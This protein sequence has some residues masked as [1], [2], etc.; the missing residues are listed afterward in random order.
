[1]NGSLRPSSTTANRCYSRL[2]R[3]GLPSFVIL[4][5]G[6]FGWVLSGVDVAL[7][8]QSGAIGNNGPAASTTEV[9]DRPTLKSGS[10]GTEVSE[11][12]ATLKLL[13]YYDGTVDG[14][15]GESTVMAVSSFQQAAGLSSDGIVGPATW[16]RLFPPT[17]A[18]SAMSMAPTTG[19]PS[20]S[21]PVSGT[22][23]RPGNPAMAVKPVAPETVRPVNSAAS[24]PMPSSTSRPVN[25]AGGVPIPSDGNKPVNS[26]GAFPTPSSTNQPVNSAAAF[27][28]PSGIKPSPVQ[29]PPSTAPTPGSAR[30]PNPSTTNPRPSNGLVAANASV[31]VP[32]TTSE[33]ISLPILRL[34]MKG[35]A[36]SGLQ[37]RLRAIGLL[38]APADGVFGKETQEAV[39]AA[40]RK[41]K[42][43]PDG[44]VGPATWVE[45]LQ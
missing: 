34:G 14:V 19:R 44:V 6:C 37:H 1:M 45:L 38:K 41:F 35:S 16:N 15:F 8:Q 3:W 33:L 40:Q 31:S 21:K 26:A 11:L 42:L 13:G 2:T 25:S 9:I 39:K 29:V 27:P 4:G 17:P 43:E 24:F 28:V 5:L 10:K 32:S 30:R 20:S 18:I 36:V 7:S 23:P 12:Q 22:A